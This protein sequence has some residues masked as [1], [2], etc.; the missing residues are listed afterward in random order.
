MI[1]TNPLRRWLRSSGRRCCAA[2]RSG[3]AG[4]EGITLIEVMISALMVGFIAIATFNGFDA[5]NRATTGERLQS[6]ATLL[7]AQSQE[8][9]RSDSAKV[10]DRIEESS[11]TYKQTV[12]G[13]TYTITESDRWVADNNQN[14]SCSA[15]GEAEHSA[16]AGNYLQVHTM[17]TWP[18]Q[19]ASGAHALEQYSIITPPDGSG[20]EVDVLNGRTPDQPVP[21]VT[22]VAGEGATASTA[23]TSEG[24]CVI[25]GGIPAIRVNVEAFKLGDVTPTGAIKK[26]DPEVL[27]AP[28]ITTHVPV[29]LNEGAKIT[30]VFT[31]EGKT[32]FAG[33]PVTGDTFVAYS[34]KLEPTPDFEVG[35]TRI[36]YPGKE[37]EY[38][39]LPGAAG[40]A[41]SYNATA[42]SPAS[43]TY[44]P[45]GDLFPFEQP[46]IVYAGDCT[47]NSPEKADPGEFP[48]ESTLP[49]VTLE[50]GANDEV[51]VPTSLV[52]LEVFKNKKSKPNEPETIIRPVKITNEACKASKTPNNASTFSYVHTQNTTSEGNLEAPFQP[53]GKSF[54][55]CLWAEKKTFTTTYANETVAGGPSI[56]LFLA[57]SSS[58]TDGHG[59][60]IE[61][62]TNQNT[63][64]C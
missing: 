29:T 46:W 41:A 27:V 61:V 24:G 58:Y 50:A 16:E 38:D 7:A 20:L 26:L 53:F 2:R 17:V 21:G 28:N 22:V 60:S 18:Q 63:N 11:H 9:L 55:L 39:A 23:T 5:A 42:I 44:Y 40:V 43:A 49:T 36:E 32:T 10:L 34:S 8:A 59:H 6:Q 57:E 25:F 14:A 64:T 47:E 45:N 12:G 4:E 56:E 35:S 31:H 62:K 37:G 33:K 13:E 48:N 30:A 52:K 51:K 15:N 3:L 1:D 54:K 19:L